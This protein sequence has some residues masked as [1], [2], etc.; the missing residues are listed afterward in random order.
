MSPPM[1]GQKCPLPISWTACCPIVTVFWGYIEKL[2]ILCPSCLEKGKCD[3]IRVY[4]FPLDTAMYKIKV[5]DP[6]LC[7]MI[8]SVLRQKPS[9]SLS[10]AL[11][12]LSHTFSVMFPTVCLKQVPNAVSQSAPML[13]LAASL[14][15]WLLLVEDCWWKLC[16][17]ASPHGCGYILPVFAGRISWD[18]KLERICWGAP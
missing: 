8:E 7:G 18:S 1:M 13:Q 16:C 2:F 11:Y 5:S 12:S 3:K 4:C 10:S 15:S 14:P 9:C 17:W 6:V